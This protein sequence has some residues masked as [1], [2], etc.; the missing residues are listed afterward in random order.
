MSSGY[1]TFLHCIVRLE[2]VAPRPPAM[3]S[4]PTS[5]AVLPPLPYF[6]SFPFSAVV[7][8][9][10]A[11]D[12]TVSATAM[13]QSE[14]SKVDINV[15]APSGDAGTPSFQPNASCM[16]WCAGDD[17]EFRVR[18]T[19]TA[20]FWQLL[21]GRYLNSRRE[22]CTQAVLVESIAPRS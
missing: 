7:I 3:S 18:R 22:I 15:V 8:L 2:Q 9:F 19:I 17:V 4:Q 11:S 1:R 20:K 14:D 12:T 13:S 6:A 21:Y 10:L 5:A 16:C